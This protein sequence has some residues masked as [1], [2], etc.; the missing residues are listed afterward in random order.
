MDRRTHTF[1]RHAGQSLR[2]SGSPQ[3]RGSG[4][5]VFSATKWAHHLPPWVH[6]GWGHACEEAA[7]VPV[8]RVPAVPLLQR[9]PRA[10][11]RLPLNKSPK[12]A[13]GRRPR[14]S[15]VRAYPPEETQM[16]SDETFQNA[17]WWLHV[18]APVPT[19]TESRTSRREF[20]NRHRAKSI[21]RLRFRQ[22]WGEGPEGLQFEQVPRCYPFENPVLTQP[23]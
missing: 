6:R 14:S 12:G 3:A 9:A 2:G 18:S 23:S 16:V 22:V 17:W 4:G 19:P 5:W 20:L 15:H 10:S 1:E 13:R 7:R 21:P 8:D 11:P